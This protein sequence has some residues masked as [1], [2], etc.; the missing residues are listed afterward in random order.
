[1]NPA[2]ALITSTLAQPPIPFNPATQTPKGW[3]VHCLRDR[4]FKVV[5][6]SPKADLIVESKAGEIGFKV[7]QNPEEAVPG[8]IGWIILDPSHQQAQ[9]VPPQD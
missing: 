2:I 9:V 1:M 3:V 6:F 5:T 8:P 7:T 4:G